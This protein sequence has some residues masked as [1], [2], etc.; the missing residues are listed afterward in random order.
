M[1]RQSNISEAERQRRAWQRAMS[2]QAFCDRYDIGR[3]RAYE[4]IHAGRLKARKAG[5]RTII[6]LDDAEEWLSRLPVFH[7]A[8]DEAAS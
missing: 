4:E 5:R 1:R 2:V 3:T 8:V 7:E 6:T